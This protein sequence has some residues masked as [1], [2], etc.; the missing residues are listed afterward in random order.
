MGMAFMGWDGWWERYHYPLLGMRVYMA[1]LRDVMRGRR[2]G[3]GATDCHIYIFLCLEPGGGGM[4]EEGRR[5]KK[6][7]AGNV[8]VESDHGKVEEGRGVINGAKIDDC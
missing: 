8:G 2:W 1:L 4:R 5:G 3:L 7:G 6:G